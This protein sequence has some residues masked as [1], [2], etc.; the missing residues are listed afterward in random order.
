MRQGTNSRER[1]LIEYLRDRLQETC[2]CIEAG[3]DIMREAGVTTSDS[4]MTVE[5]A[6]LFIGEAN[7]YLA[8]LTEVEA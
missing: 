8:G 5:G 7:Q 6:Q 1:Q 2:D 4:Q 3:Y